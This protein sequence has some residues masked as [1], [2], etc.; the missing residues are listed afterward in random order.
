MYLRVLRVGEQFEEGVTVFLVICNIMLE[1]R[2][3]CGVESLGLAAG[4][5]MISGGCYVLHSKVGT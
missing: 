2:H 1:A 5:W 4:L 3:Y